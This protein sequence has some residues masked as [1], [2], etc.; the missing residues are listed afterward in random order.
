ME[1]MSA[2]FDNFQILICG[3]IS[4][5]ILFQ[6]AIVAP[7]VFQTLPEGQAGPFLRNLFPK[8]F[9]LCATLMGLNALIAIY[10]DDLI[11]AC[12]FILGILLMVF[13]LLLVP[14]IN[15]ARDQNNEPVFKRLH[16]STVSSTL[17]V[18]LINLWFS[19]A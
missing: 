14:K 11:P 18:L 2:F 3:V 15:N 1:V 19:L 7:A 12:G 4:G 16:L 10:F 13:C 6:S 8:L 5:F 9:K 17:I